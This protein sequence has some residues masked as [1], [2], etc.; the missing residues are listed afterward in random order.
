MTLI[1]GLVIAFINGWKM[2]LVVVACLP[3]II[4]G[5]VIQTKYTIGAADKVCA[6][7]Q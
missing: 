2:S 7:W 5:A 3:L 1:G 6:R 4:F